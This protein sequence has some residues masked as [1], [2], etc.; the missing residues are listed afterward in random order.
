MKFLHYFYIFILIVIFP[1]LSSAGVNKQINF[2]WEY[3]ITIKDLAGYILY[4][5]GKQLHIV[6]D[7]KALSVDLNVEITP[8]TTESFTMKAFDINKN[9]SSL[10]APYT[11]SVP[12]NVEN[13]NFLPNAVISHTQGSIYNNI[14][15]TAAG[16]IDFDGTIS[17]YEW[18]FGDGKNE[19]LM[20]DTPISH[21]YL[22]DGEYTITLKITDNSGGI[23]IATLSMTIKNPLNA[24]QNFKVIFL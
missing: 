20:G 9:E 22:S 5:N 7:P 2:E 17:K 3:D 16:S 8:G 11:L 14:L 13:N 18:N 23:N 15:L 6:N 1:S 24:P 19:T 12:N 4:Q 21:I 10:S